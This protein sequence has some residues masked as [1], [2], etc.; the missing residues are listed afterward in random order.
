MSKR[1]PTLFVVLT[2][3]T[4][5][6]AWVEQ[7]IIAAGASSESALMAALDNGDI[8]LADDDLVALVPQRSWKPTRVKIETT[9][10][11]VLKR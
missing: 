4:E 7:S 2:F 10:R 3:D 6:R 9:Q 5:K 8:Q 11:V 1:V